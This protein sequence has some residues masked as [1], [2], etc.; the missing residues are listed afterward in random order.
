M[1]SG[2][3]SSREVAR[4]QHDARDGLRL[5]VGS[6][7]VTDTTPLGVG[8]A[9]WLA[10]ELMFL[11]T[12]LFAALKRTTD[13]WRFGCAFRGATGVFPWYSSFQLH[14]HFAVRP[15]TG[16][17]SALAWLMITRRAPALFLGQL[18]EYAVR[19][20]VEST[21][22]ARSLHTHGVSA[23][24]GAGLVA[25]TI[26]IWVVFSRHSHVPSAHTLRSR[27][28]AWSMWVGRGIPHGVRVAMIHPP[29]EPLIRCCG[30][31][32]LRGRRRNARTVGPGQRR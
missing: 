32:H 27:S 24:R 8:V 29:A 4:R 20:H 21:P 5:S 9:I 2:H 16:Q 6:K 19:L 30:R 26:V 31:K 18:L 17:A 15:R 3:G 28:Y 12:L 13:K 7:S 14:S 22:S 10:S 11:W 25:L 1:S 23:A